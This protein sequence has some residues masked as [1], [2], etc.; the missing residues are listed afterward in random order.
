MPRPAELPG[1][2]IP[3]QPSPAHAQAKRVSGY[4]RKARGG[5]FF[6]L[7]GAIASGA[8]AVVGRTGRPLLAVPGYPGSGSG[9]HNWDL[10]RHSYPKPSSPPPPPNFCP[11]ADRE[12]SGPRLLPSYAFENPAWTLKA[13]VDFSRPNLKGGA[14]SS[15]FFP[16]GRASTR[17]PASCCSARAPNPGTCLEAPRD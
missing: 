9:G 15:Q 7:T 4:L 1:A 12:T 17:Q 10:S 5:H 16:G 6:L 13:C 3:P 14:R 8:A 2:F 11:C